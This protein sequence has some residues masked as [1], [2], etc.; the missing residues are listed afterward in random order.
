MKSWSRILIWLCLAGVL[1][2]LYAPLLPPLLLAVRDSTTGNITL[3]NF[4][5]I[6][7]DPTL[8]GALT[9]SV[10]LAA[11]VGVAA[12]LLGL[13]AAQAVRYF[14]VPRLIVTVI[15]L[16]LFI[17]GVSM[18]V[19]SSLFFNLTG[20]EP[21]LLTM[22][23]VQTL[24]AL[25]FA[26]LIILTVMAGFDTLYLEAAYTCGANRTQAFWDI[27]VPQIAPGI[28]G[29]ATFS[30]ILSFNE[31]VR[32]AVVQGGNNTVQTFIWSR[33][34]Q[35]GLTPNMYALMTI[36]IAITLL[37]IL[38]LVILGRERHPAT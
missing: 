38:V 2:F 28:S 19:S 35:V 14:G 9:N 26:F 29:A 27:E 5:T 32:T 24:W 31:T 1:G 13:A 3:Q 23:T 18:G 12:P 8:V 25:P 7:S 17:P 30:V 6:H 33:Y 22:A 16:P 37:L 4:G 34:Q 11:I 15:L 21:S 20:F 10:L 36:I